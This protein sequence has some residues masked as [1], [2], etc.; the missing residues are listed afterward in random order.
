MCDTWRF[1]MTL[2]GVRREPGP[3]I[4]YVEEII[5]DDDCVHDTAQQGTQCQD[6][7]EV[8]SSA[9]YKMSHVLNCTRAQNQNVAAGGG[10]VSSSFSTGPHSNKLSDQLATLMPRFHGA[11]VMSIVRLLF[12]L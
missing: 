1:T 12:V 10:G 2:L 3:N 7:Q 11:L 5:S 8:E 6:G 9:E 4:D